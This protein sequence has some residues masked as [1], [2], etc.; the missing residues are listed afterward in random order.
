MQQQALKQDAAAIAE[1]FRRQPIR[2]PVDPAFDPYY[3]R[4]LKGDLA[5]VLEYGGFDVFMMDPDS[6]FYEVVGRLV[7]LHSF[8]AAK[9]IIS[10]IARRGDPTAPAPADVYYYWNSKLRL[11][12]CIARDF[13]REQ[14]KADGS[15]KREKLWHEYVE[16][17]SRTRLIKKGTARPQGPRELAARSQVIKELKE[18]A[19]TMHSNSEDVRS[20][21]DLVDRFS[22]F[23]LVPKAIFFELAESD[24]HAERDSRY[25]ARRLL[26]TP[27]AVARKYAGLMAGVSA[28]TMSHKNVRK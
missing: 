13:I 22:M 2:Q 3:Q 16:T 1:N 20:L 12:C 27:S 18:W 10:E 8:A 21:Y 5:A 23:F 11:C 6:S 4:I 28:S 7:A 26:K 9:R 25:R 14:Y 24:S 15:V 19:Q 17:C